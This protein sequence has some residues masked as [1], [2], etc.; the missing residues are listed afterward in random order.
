MKILVLLLVL[1][2]PSFANHWT[3]VH[4]TSTPVQGLTAQ[5]P[6][7][8]PHLHLQRVKT[9]KAERDALMAHPQVDCVDVEDAFPPVRISSAPS[10]GLDRIDSR[11]GL[12]NVYSHVVRNETRVTVYVV[13]TGIYVRHAAFEDRASFGARFAIAVDGKDL[14]GH[15]TH[16]AGIIGSSTH[17]V[18]RGVNLIALKAF[19]D[20][21]WGEW[22]HIAEAFEWISNDAE[23]KIGVVNL[24]FH[25]HQM[26]PSIAMA[27]K[28][29]QAQGLFIVMSAGNLNGNTPCYPASSILNENIVLSVGAVDT[30]D[31][32]DDDDEVYNH[33]ALYSASG[34]CISLF[35]PGT[36][37]IS[38][39]NYPDRLTSMSGTSQAAAFVSGVL[40]ELLY[41]SV[42]CEA[43]DGSVDRSEGVKHVYQTLLDFA[44]TDAVKD[45][46]SYWGSS[47]LLYSPP[48]GF[49]QVSCELSSIPS[50]TSNPSP[51]SSPS[52]TSN[53]NNPTSNPSPTSPTSNLSNPTLGIQLF[54]SSRNH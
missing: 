20:A 41:S 28:N 32:L 30:Y 27:L 45:D 48:K 38:I 3:L 52:P 50:P 19:D 43:G 21:G 17:G 14:N 26:P 33:R 15:G 31:P 12:D 53:P 9:N 39:D 4:W 54:G 47:L 46:R 11:A 36:G 25:G 1:L 18:T 16:V 2:T 51:T 5:T 6:Q 24:S 8:F 23:G 13:D 34:P 7:E 22:E 29:L 42:G 35:A 37:I 40:A 10:W 49:P 44:T